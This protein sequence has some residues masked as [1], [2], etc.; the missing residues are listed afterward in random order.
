MVILS[1]KF[2]FD[3]VFGCL[4]REKEKKTFL[5]K[6]QRFVETVDQYVMEKKR[7]IISKKTMYNN[8]NLRNSQSPL[9]SMHHCWE[10]C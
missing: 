10:I 1:R 7:T 4:G 9:G 8:I 5:A 2:A 3:I 6:Y